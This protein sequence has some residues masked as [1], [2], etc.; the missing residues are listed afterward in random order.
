M[1]SSSKFVASLFAGSALA[2]PAFAQLAPPAPI[3][4]SVDQNGVNLFDGNLYVNGPVLSMGQSDPQGLQ[5]YKLSRNNGW[6]DNIVAG[7][8][9]EGTIVTVSLAGF[10]DI[11]TVSGSTYTNTQGNGATLT[12]TLSTYTY[13]RADGTLIHFSKNLSTPAPYYANQGRP[14]DITFPSGLKLVFTYQDQIYCL[15]WK[16]GGSGTF[17]T[18][19]AHM[20]RP[21]T[22]RNSYGYQ[23][24]FAYNYDYD[25]NPDSPETQPNFY[26]WSQSNGVTATNLAVSSGASTPTQTWSSPT[27]YFQV[28]DP[29]GRVTKYR[30]SGNQVLGITLPG[31]TSEDE[32]INYTSGRVTSVVTPAGTTNYGSSDLS[33]VRTVTVTDPLSH[34]TTYTFD[35][36]SQTLTSV[37]DPNSHTTAA[38]YDT[39]GRITQV[40]K[41]EGNYTHWTYDGRGNITEQRQVAKSGSGL[42]D[43]VATASYPSTCSNPLTCNEPTT[44]IAPNGAATDYTYDATSGSVLTITQPA[45]LPGAV[46]PQTRY[47][48][49]SLQ[50][51]FKNT[52]GSIVASGEPVV[53]LT[54]ISACQTTASCTGTSDET[55]AT[56]GYGPQ[57]TGVGNNLLPVSISRGDGTGALTATTAYTYDDVGNTTYVDG[58][59]SGTAD[60]TRALYDADREQLGSIDPD[61]DG[62]GALLN[63][64]VRNTIDS[65]GLLT[66]VE[67]GTTSGQTD[68]AWAA[69]STAQQVDITYDSRRRVTTRKLSSGGTNYALA[70]TD[71]YSDDRLQCSALRMNT[72][73]YAS[74]PSSAC[75]LGTQ[76]SYGPDRISKNVYDNAGQLT[77]VQ[78]AVGTSDAANE[79]TLSYTNNG[80][81]QTLTDGE[82]NKTTYVFDGFDR[83][84]QSQ[85]PSATKGSG[86]S[87]PSDYE[88]LTY[89]A[90]SNVSQYRARSGDLIGLSH[91]YLDR[92][93]HKGGSSIADRDYTWDN[94]DR[95]LTSIFSTGG[96]GVTNTYDALSRLTSSTTNMDGIART[97]NS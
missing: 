61:P 19:T 91:D 85:Y 14:T 5:F 81:L 34:V 96:L 32:T 72:S 78:V 54:G 37:T 21:L 18:N 74:L 77:Q 24:S 38:Q 51:Y 44:T 84:S 58:P 69:F 27:G 73:V 22:V 33:G 89:D 52:S 83:L 13:T 82:N 67:L 60:T 26:L 95:M 57:T 68:A 36:A 50:A 86:T 28:T 15:T 3:H 92:L 42:S 30:M 41:P 76:G 35:I 63:R 40:T 48:Y 6:T 8:D 53:M 75:T 39:Y 2:S 43:V 1:K 25:Y 88:Q 70:Q 20:Y 71:Y 29:M 56:I 11:F 66:K 17:C 94:L 10:T 47:S 87:N 79:R 55:K 64:A 46:R 16:T 4:Q 62:A 90:D 59:L 93:I 23:L 97:M 7:L 45:P 49:S 12:S 9:L 80:M 31:S 65:R